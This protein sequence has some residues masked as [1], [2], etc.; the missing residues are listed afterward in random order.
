MDLDLSNEL[1][2]TIFTTNHGGATKPTFI[3]SVMD[4]NL[5]PTEAQYENNRPVYYDAITNEYFYH[6]HSI[7]INDCDTIRSLLVFQ[8]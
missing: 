4:N 2:G 6:S 7:E 8:T 1:D 3:L 5:I